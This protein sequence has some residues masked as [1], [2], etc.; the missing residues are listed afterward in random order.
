MKP[1]KEHLAKINKFTQT[2][3]TEDEVAVHQFLVG[4]TNVTA[5][6]TVFDI[7]TLR[8]FAFDLMQ[9]Q[10][11]MSIHHATRSVLP[12]GRSFDGRIDSSKKA[13]VFG[14]FY[15]PLALDEH[16]VS[17]RI[18]A[19]TVFDVSMGVS[20]SRYECNICNNDFRSRLC[21]HWPGQTYNVG[22]DEKPKM[23]E[24][25]LLMKGADTA[26][27]N[28]P[29]GEMFAD[30]ALSETSAVT[31]GAVPG[32]GVV[33]GAFCDEEKM[34]FCFGDIK[35][36]KFQQTEGDDEQDFTTYSNPVVHLITPLHYDKETEDMADVAELMAKLEQFQKDV[37]SRLD[38]AKATHQDEI[39]RL[40]A[41]ITELQTKLTE[42]ETKLAGATE[43]V[44]AL[45]DFAAGTLVHYRTKLEGNGFDSE[46]ARK[47]YAN[48][49]VSD[50]TAKLT[51]L[52]EQ[53]AAKYAAGRQTPKEDLESGKP[54]VPPAFD[55]LFRV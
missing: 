39:T 44:S 49:T 34:E 52:R 20:V 36:K 1:T 47:E 32:A 2:P 17:A 28:G 30:C 3:L 46:V 10:T 6:K 27:V 53:V 25:L 35:L 50:F 9:G 37:E 26:V 24:C 18:D 31:D 21:T 8:K 41:T 19:G 54:D 43:E 33:R 55:N 42:T 14:M 29:F 48:L 51:D 23:K 5:Y 4:N 38:T 11:A 15:V 45:K 40:N 22:T 16:K 12:P 7:R 13:N